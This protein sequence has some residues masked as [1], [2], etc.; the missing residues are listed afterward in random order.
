M[1]RGSGRQGLAS[2][3]TCN[4][5][6]LHDQQPVPHTSTRN[7]ASEHSSTWPPVARLTT[8]RC[9][10]VYRAHHATPSATRLARRH[11][12]SLYPR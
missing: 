1:T 7:A 3:L 4:T 6:V 11:A 5:C 10:N 9:A 2:L 12:L 8:M